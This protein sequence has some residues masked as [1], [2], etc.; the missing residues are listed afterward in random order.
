MEGKRTYYYNL[1]DDIGGGPYQGSFTGNLN[2]PPTTSV[3]HFREAVLKEN[4]HLLGSLGVTSL[5]VLDEE[6]FVDLNTPLQDIG[7]NDKK[8]LTVKV[9][10]PR[11]SILETTTIEETDAESVL[12]ELSYYRERGSLIQRTNTEYCKTILDRIDEFAK[13][14]L[15]TPFICV[16]GSSGMGKSQLAFA[17]HGR[18]PYFYWLAASVVSTSQKIYQNFNAIS[19]EFH[20]FVALDNPTSTA[21][22]EILNTMS[23]TYSKGK[24]WTFG[25]IRS[26]LNYCS[27]QEAMEPTM[28]HFAKEAS[29]DVT[30]CTRRDVLIVID[31]MVEKKKVLPFFVL[32]ELTL[33]DVEGNQIAAFQRNVFRVCGL[34]VI[35]MGTD[36]KESSLTAQS[37][38]SYCTEHLWMAIVP[39]FPT[40]C[41]LMDENMDKNGKRFA[42]LFIEQVL[43]NTNTESIKLSTLLDDAFATINTR[44]QHG[45]EYLCSKDGLY[46]Q[47]MAVS[48]SNAKKSKRN[49]DE[50][51]SPSKHPR[52]HI[53]A[54]SMHAHFSNL[55]EERMT[56]LYWSANSLLKGSQSWKATCSFPP[57]DKDLVLYLSILGGKEISTYQDIIIGKNFSTKFVFMT[58]KDDSIAPLNGF[59]TLENMVAHA[60]FCSSRRNGAQG[61]AFHDFLSCLFGEFQDEEW[62]KMSELY[63]VHKE[64]KQ[65]MESLLREYSN[66]GMEMESNIESELGL[67][68]MLIPFL[69][70]PNSQWPLEL[71]QAKEYG[72]YFGNLI[73]IMNEAECC[74]Y[75]EDLLVCECKFGTSNVNKTTILKFVDSMC[76]RQRPWKIALVFCHKFATSGKETWTHNTIG[77]ARINVARCHFEW[78]FQPETPS[79]PSDRKQLVLVVELPNSNV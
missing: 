23:R 62:K 28:I 56:D 37:T 18:R 49:S 45:K 77:C 44:M 66:S 30:K 15:P 79:R 34:V 11:P 55:V 5:G 8:P 7:T 29:L 38:D 67:S 72:C 16:Q 25:F 31:G 4:S 19:Q 39:H 3:A 69:A 20:H 78:I 71:L 46:A 9:R 13:S 42:R 40:Y 6:R 74:I 12:K 53:R 73:R 26:L 70:P 17:L 33:N 59:Q 1:V 60:I 32:D 43:S 41:M 24:L 14:E 2:L 54:S 48:Y 64:T 68:D 61:I 57:V 58:T 50:R 36:A 21:K 27:S 63:V 35:L 65:T 75:V 76:E 10:H 52:L 51:D 22:E 47:R